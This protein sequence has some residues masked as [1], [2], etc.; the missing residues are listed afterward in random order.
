M[1]VLTHNQIHK[2]LSLHPSTADIDVG[3]FHL[4][5]IG[6]RILLPSWLQAAALS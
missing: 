3:A 1:Q 5:P 2:H 6:Y 4:L